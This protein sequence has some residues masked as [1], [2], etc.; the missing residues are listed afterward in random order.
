MHQSD[1]SQPNRGSLDKTQLAEFVQGTSS[2]SSA[3]LERSS[4]SRH[5]GGN[6]RLSQIEK[7]H[8]QFFVQVRHVDDLYTRY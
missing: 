3:D 6:V 2:L 7:G 5:A 1:E 8:E 4:Q